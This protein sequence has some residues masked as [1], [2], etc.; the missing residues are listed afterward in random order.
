MTMFMEET[1]NALFQGTPRPWVRTPLGL[2][3]KKTYSNNF[4]TFDYKSKGPGSIP[5]K[6]TW[7]CGLVV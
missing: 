1:P 7:S 4:F 5:G 3:I 2:L 6:T